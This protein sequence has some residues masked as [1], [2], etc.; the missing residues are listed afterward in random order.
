[1]SERCFEY[2]F[3]VTKVLSDT[4]FAPSTFE[5]QQSTTLEPSPLDRRPS[6]LFNIPMKRISSGLSF[7]STR[8]SSDPFVYA[9]DSEVAEK[10]G[11]G[12][13]KDGEYYKSVIL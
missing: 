13:E 10:G 8:K 6:S 3:V 12:G 5:S 7:D 4:D 11:E 2:E 9:I 1:M